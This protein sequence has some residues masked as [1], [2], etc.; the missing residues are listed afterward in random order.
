VEHGL[1]F[2]LPMYVSATYT[3]AEFTGANLVAGGG[4]GVYAGARDGNEI[5]Y[6]PEWKLAA[7]IG[8]SGE[9]W[10]VRLD[11][12]YMGSTWGSGFNDDVNPTPSIRDGKI[13]ALLLFDLTAD[14]QINDNFKFLAGVLNVFDEREMVSRIPEGPRANAPRMIF[15]GIEMTF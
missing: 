13:P 3:V 11:A 6:I 2:G 4:D 15:G 9:K 8:V 1:A 7:G 5:P 10:E 14:Y 12:S